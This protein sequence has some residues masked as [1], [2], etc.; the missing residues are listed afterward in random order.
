L[1]SIEPFLLIISFCFDKNTKGGQAPSMGQAGEEGWAKCQSPSIGWGGYIWCST[2]HREDKERA[3]TVDSG[4]KYTKEAGQGQDER[5]REA[6]NF[7]EEK[8]ANMT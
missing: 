7:K 8:R 1:I 6:T 4:F 3:R 5:R 2:E